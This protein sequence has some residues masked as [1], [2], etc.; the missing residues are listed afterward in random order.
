MLKF[1]T[2]QRVFEVGSVKIGG[3][4]GEN[5]TVLIG[6]IFYHGHKILV[7]E[8]TVEFHR[9]EAE[10]LIKASSFKRSFRRE[11]ETLV[12][13]TSQPPLRKLWRSS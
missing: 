5:P 12:C 4:P 7:N 10:K 11:L 8:K 2:Q 3:Q 9:E 1:K 13:W 6:S